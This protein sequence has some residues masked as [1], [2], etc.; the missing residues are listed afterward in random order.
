VFELDGAIQQHSQRALSA[1]AASPDA[2]ARG[3]P[4]IRSLKLKRLRSWMSS[5]PP[6]IFLL[7]PARLDGKRAHLLFHPVTMFPVARALHSTA[8]APIGEIFS[9]LRRPGEGF[10]IG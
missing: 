2:K 10:G 3:G 6:R 1:A 4:S 5:F 7:S 9:F 8:G